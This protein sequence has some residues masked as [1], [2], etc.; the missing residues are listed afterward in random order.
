[1]NV[2]ERKGAAGKNKRPSAVRRR[3]AQRWAAAA[4]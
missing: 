3:G 2:S 1:M 4:L